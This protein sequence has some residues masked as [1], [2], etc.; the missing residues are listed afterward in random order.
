MLLKDWDLLLF[1]VW[2]R[3]KVTTTVSI[4]WCADDSLSILCIWRKFGLQLKLVF[5]WLLFELLVTVVFGLMRILDIGGLS[6]I[7]EEVGHP[8]FG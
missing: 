3:N 4:V 1:L 7:A 8:E 6:T 5:G 2:T